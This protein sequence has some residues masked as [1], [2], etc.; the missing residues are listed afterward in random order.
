MKTLP[1]VPEDL[2]R[3][4]GAHFERACFAVARR[5]IAP[6]MGERLSAE[7]FVRKQWHDDT[8]TPLVVRAAS[9]PAMTTT[10]AWPAWCAMS[11]PTFSARW[12]R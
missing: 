6:Q 7:S 10:H 9:P 12:R 4:L 8:I 5:A 11:S 2:R 1:L 3:P